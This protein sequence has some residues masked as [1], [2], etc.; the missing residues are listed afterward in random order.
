MKLGVLMI[1]SGLVGF[2]AAQ[3]TV[4]DTISVND[5]Y[6]VIKVAQTGNTIGLSD[7][8]SSYDNC[9]NSPDYKLHKLV[10]QESNVN[11]QCV[12]K[13]PTYR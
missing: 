6:I 13:L 2:L 3:I 5:H 12:N 1:I 7:K 10:S 8:F 9:I 4:K 11:I